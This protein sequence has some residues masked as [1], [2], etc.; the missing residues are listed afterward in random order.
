MPETYTVMENSTTWADIE[1]R[2]QEVLD[3]LTRHR[4]E[5]WP[6][7]LAFGIIAG[8][9]LTVIG[10]I[11]FKFSL[12]LLVVTAVL[13]FVIA[14]FY[15]EHKRNKIYK[16]KVMPRLLEVICPGATYN[17]DG[18]I[19]F[20]VITKSKLFRSNLTY[21]NEDTIRGKVGS[22]DFIYG[23]V[24]L[25]HMQGTGKNRRKVIDFKGFVFEADF[26]KD[27]NGITI[28]STEGFGF[29]LMKFTKMNRCHLEDARFEERYHTYTNNDQQARYI[30]TPSLQE[31]ILN[32]NKTFSTQLGDRDLFMSFHDS[33]M[34]I[35]VPSRT[36]RFEVKYK[37]VDVKGDYIAL[38]LMIDIVNQLN[39]N[40]RIWSKE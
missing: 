20:S 4:S 9:I 30:L 18:D 7:T 1:P 32:M 21:S 34:L 27:F 35:M 17:P 31:R 25:S 39:L 2:I 15:Y 36:N 14:Y 28:L 19:P 37:A 29:F 33:R 6:K 11:I 16:A 12:I 3:E 24:E 5:S 23:E 40:L 26:N 38:T 13:G 22:T 10:S 8:L